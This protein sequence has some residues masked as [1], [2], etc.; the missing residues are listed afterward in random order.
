MTGRDGFACGLGEWSCGPGSPGN[1]K[2]VAVTR[3]LGHALGA[4]CSRLVEQGGNQPWPAG[5]PW[6]GRRL[7]CLSF[8]EILQFIPHVREGGVKLRGVSLA[9]GGGPGLWPKGASGTLQPMLALATDVLA[10]RSLLSLPPRSLRRT[11][12]GRQ[13]TSVQAFVSMLAATPEREREGD[14]EV[15]GLGFLG[16]PVVYEGRT[17]RGPRQRRPCQGAGVALERRCGVVEKG[18]APK[19]ARLGSGAGE[20]GANGTNVEVVVSQPLVRDLA[21]KEAGGVSF[22]VVLEA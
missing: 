21:L 3:V 15:T 11:S 12:F 2:R 9:L 7:E 4:G 18:V 16:G 10:R 1:R 13:G 6:S 8:R 22:H 19:A 17:W 5:I 20:T 14:Q